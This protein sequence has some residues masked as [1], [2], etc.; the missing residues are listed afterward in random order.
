MKDLVYAL[1]HS[2]NYL[3]FLSVIQNDKQVFTRSHRERGNK[4]ITIKVYEQNTNLNDNREKK[5]SKEMSHERGKIV[6]IFA[7]WLIIDIF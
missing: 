7:A 2:F 1:S 6:C 3:I 5:S 4:S